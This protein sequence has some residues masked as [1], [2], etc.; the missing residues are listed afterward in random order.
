MCNISNKKINILI[1]AGEPSGDI[2]ASLLMKELKKIHNYIEFFGIGGKKMEAEGLKSIIPLEEISVV[3]IIEVTKRARLWAKL[4]SQCKKILDNENIN[5]FIP[6]DY[7]GFNIEIAKYAK[8][9]NIPVYYYIAPQLWAWGENRWKKLKNITDILFVILP[10]EEKY[11]NERGIR[12]IYVGHPLLDIP[13]F[14]EDII[15]AE[16]K[17]NII[18]FFP[19]SRKQEID[20]NL[21]L[22]AETAAE[23]HKTYP[24]FEYA[25][26]ISSNVKKEYFDKL[27]KYKLKYKLYYDSH[28]LMRKAK[29]GIVKA[30]TTTLEAALLGMNMIMAY[31]T[32]FTHYIFGKH[33]I[34]LE[35]IA[36]PNIILEENIIPEFIQRNA[37]KQKLCH[38]IKPFLENSEYCK[39]Q[40]HK[41]AK[42]KGILGKSGASQ[43]TAQTVMQEMNR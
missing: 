2:H 37:N 28:E 32:S 20:K 34:N 9:I 41:F 21:Y 13:V 6:V 16:N 18:G 15:P 26:A 11:F 39:Y 1:I 29:V 30:G 23:L 7:P 5:C 40:Q 10:F 31:K 24:E 22:F 4:I 8:K 42:L 14:S 35:Y 33:L 25:F 3:G 27:N 43:N 38:G 17:E 36:L 19:G 12:S